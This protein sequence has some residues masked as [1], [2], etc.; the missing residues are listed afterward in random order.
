M[1]LIISLIVFIGIHAFVMTLTGGFLNFYNLPSILMVLPTS[2][3][4]GLS[5]TSL[6]SARLAIC[7]CFKQERAESSPEIENAIRFFYVTGTSAVYLGVGA[8]FFAFVSAGS[9]LTTIYERMPDSIGS[10]MVIIV[11]APMYAA[12]FKLLC[13]VGEQSIRSKIDAQIYE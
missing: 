8:F 9:N 11:L 6:S 12:Y 13:F 2:I 1:L 3:L 5:A 7:S 4:F 10:A